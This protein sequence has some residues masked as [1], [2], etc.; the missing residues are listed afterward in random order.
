MGIKGLNPF[1]E[2]FSPECMVD[3]PYSYF[4]GKRIAID[5]DNILVKL[6]S[7]SH[8]Q[9]VNHTDVCVKD[10]DRKVIVRTWLS[11]IKEDMLK[12]LNYGITPVWVFDGK[13]IPEKAATQ[14]ERREKKRTAVEEAEKLK[15]EMR[16]LDPLEITPQMVKQ[17]REKMQ[18][19]GTILPEEKELAKQLL[20]SLGI[21]VLRATGEGEK[22]C[23][24]LCVEGKVEAVLST[25]TDSV[26]MGCPML[27]KKDGIYVTNPNTKTRELGVSCTIFKPILDKLN[28]EYASFLDLCIMGRCDFNKNIKG[29]ALKNA[30]KMLKE[31][32]SIEKLPAKYDESK[33]IL[34]HVKCR[35]IFR[36]EKSSDICQ[37][38]PFPCLNIMTNFPLNQR[39]SE[40]NEEIRGLLEVLKEYEIDVEEWVDNFRDAYKFLPTPS[41]MCVSKYPSLAASR[42]R[43]KIG[44]SF[45]ISKNVVSE[46]QSNEVKV[47][48]KN[49]TIESVLAGGVIGAPLII[50]T[51]ASPEKM[52]KGAVEALANQQYL[53]YLEKNEMKKNQIDTEPIQVY[54][55]TSL[56]VPAIPIPTT[57]DI[58]QPIPKKPLRLNI[59]KS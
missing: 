36:L 44:P 2:E 50:G 57:Q 4:K 41:D 43:M 14:Q 40:I 52:K 51:H 28:M 45:T 25:D 46:E 6:M 20:Q 29:V 26:A 1:L 38:D 19:L 18:N 16:L 10:P 32:K 9:V 12:K 8:K 7:R 11:H 54:A 59:V 55:N 13:Y 53:K 27:I 33:S 3:V 31:C 35:E 48:T 42:L 56:S 39:S 22:L 34:N 17:L 49:E 37:N 30:Y 24:M 23:A 15:A 21:P 47:E 58:L 5:G